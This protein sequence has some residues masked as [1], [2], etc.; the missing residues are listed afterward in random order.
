MASGKLKRH[1]TRHG[2][3]Q[4]PRLTPKGVPPHRYALMTNWRANLLLGG[5]LTFGANQDMYIFYVLE[6]AQSCRLV[7]ARQKSTTCPA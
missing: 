4:R 5:P 7:K 6:T 3:R 1:S 2:A